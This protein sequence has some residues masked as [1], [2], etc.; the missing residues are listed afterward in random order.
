MS[1]KPGGR[2]EKG[3]RQTDTERETDRQRDRETERKEEEE[4][5]E[6]KEERGKGRG[7]KRRGGR[8]MERTLVCGGEATLEPHLL[9]TLY[10]TWSHP[11][12]SMDDGLVVGGRD[13]TCW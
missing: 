2:G 11:R 4:R 8:R 3:E 13:R 12:F 6:R 5:G 9:G 10:R 1:P 7:E